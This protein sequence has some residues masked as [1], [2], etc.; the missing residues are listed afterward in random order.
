MNQNETI[1]VTKWWST[2]GIVKM[3][4]NIGGGPNRMAIQ[5]QHPRQ[6]FRADEWWGTE[7]AAVRH[8]REVLIPRCILELKD[9]LVRIQALEVR[10][11]DGDCTGP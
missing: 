11:I 2:R 4:A 10:I 3:L 8:V 9:E 1:W 6:A 5:A 7:Q